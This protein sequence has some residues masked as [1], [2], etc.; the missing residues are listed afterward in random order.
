LF[1]GY[2]AGRLRSRWIGTHPHEIFFRDT[3][4]GFVA[5][6]LATVFVAATVASSASSIFGGGV[7]AASE[8]AA[9]A[10]NSIE[11]EASDSALGYNIDKTFRSVG[12]GEPAGH[13]S[14]PRLEASRIVMQAMA[15]G[16]V[17]AA[18]RAYL[19]RIVAARTGVS[20]TEAQKRVDDL[21]DTANAA[22]AKVMAE[23]DAA[24]KTAAEVGIYTAL[25]LLIGAFIASVAAA[26]G[27]H[28]RDQH[29]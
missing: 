29:L 14:D 13:G 16:S 22:K 2:I 15:S 12:A 10:E 26:L 5:W 4:H 19:A 8:A 11:Q 3:A 25:A 1:G 23:A 28:L 6:S 18:D 24:R 21:I 9:G 27:G 17:P 7:K 20:E